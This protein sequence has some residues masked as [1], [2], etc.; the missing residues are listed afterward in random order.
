MK[1]VNAGYELISEES[2]TKQIERVARVCYK[3]EGYIKDGTD[4]KM[5]GKLQYI[6]HILNNCL[7]LEFLLLLQIDTVFLKNLC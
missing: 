3:S 1:I 5:L 7:V 4:V 2:V 6:Y